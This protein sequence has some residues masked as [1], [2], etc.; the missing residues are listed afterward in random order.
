MNKYVAGLLADAIQG[1]EVKVL[2][3]HDD[4]VNVIELLSEKKIEELRKSNPPMILSKL[5]VNSWREL[6]PKVE[7]III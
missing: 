5:H 7:R 4:S 1:D 3:Q 2:T 6:F